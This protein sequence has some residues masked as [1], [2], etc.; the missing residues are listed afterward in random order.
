MNR[1]CSVLVRWD[2]K[3]EDYCACSISLVLLLLTALWA[4]WDRL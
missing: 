4:Y 2:K 1:F 3:V